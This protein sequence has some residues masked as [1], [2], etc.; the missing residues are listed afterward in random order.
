MTVEYAARMR[1]IRVVELEGLR[2]RLSFARKAGTTERQ[3]DNEI[4]RGG[5]G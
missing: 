2:E 3:K 1:S 4:Q 5:N